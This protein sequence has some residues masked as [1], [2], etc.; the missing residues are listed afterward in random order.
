[1]VTSDRAAFDKAIEEERAKCDHASSGSYGSIDFSGTAHV[2]FTNGQ[3]Q[4]EMRDDTTDA[5]RYLEIDMP[6]MHAKQ[7]GESMRR[8]AI[9]DSL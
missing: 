9:Q 8:W 4:I 2:E 5:G 6:H 7:L 1:M 3:L